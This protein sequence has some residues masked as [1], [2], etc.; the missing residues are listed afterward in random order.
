MRLAYL[1]VGMVAAVLIALL[2]LFVQ[3]SVFPSEPGHPNTTQPGIGVAGATT[4]PGSP[5]LQSSSP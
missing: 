2:A 1:A 4:P 5:S 3:G